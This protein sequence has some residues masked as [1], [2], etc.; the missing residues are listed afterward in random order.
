MLTCKT[1]GGLGNVL[2]QLATTIALARRNNDQAYYFSKR[3]SG[4]ETQHY[5]TLEKYKDNI[6]SRLL[7]QSPL[8]HQNTYKE[9]FFHY[10]EIPYQQDTQLIGYFQSPK[11]FEDQRD[12]LLNL[13]APTPTITRRL[14]NEFKSLLRLQTVSVHVRRGDYLKFQNIHP[15]LPVSYYEEALQQIPHEVVVVFSDDLAWT[16]KTFKGSK[17]YFIKEQ[18]DYLDLY[19]MSMC[20]HNIISN[21]TFSW[22]GAWLNKNSPIVVAPK[23]WFSTGVRH[24]TNDLYCEEWLL[25]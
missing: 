2:F 20:K 16:Q 11:Y 10:K 14:V 25:L 7:D 17:F 12:Y 3:K 15:L 9:P 18:E 8:K 22:W 21:S 24:N 19:L 13:F 1:K 23:K 5:P 4:S 6:L